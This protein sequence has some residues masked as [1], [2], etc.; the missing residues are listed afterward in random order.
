MMDRIG[1]SHF[2]Q[3][4][5]FSVILLTIIL[6]VGSHYLGAD[7][8]NSL[9]LHKWILGPHRLLCKVSQAVDESK[10]AAIL[11]SWRLSTHQ[12]LVAMTGKFPN[13]SLMGRITLGKS[14]LEKC[15]GITK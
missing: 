1:T 7:V 11:R 10:T 12:L 2:F 13:F 15:S 5:F 14:I 9:D 6:S 8:A 4:F 3:V